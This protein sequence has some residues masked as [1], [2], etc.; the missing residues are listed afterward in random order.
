MINKKSA[1]CKDCTK[2]SI[3]CHGGCDDYAEYQEYV[4][5]IKS[6]RAVM[7]FAHDPLYGYFHERK[8]KRMHAESRSA[9]L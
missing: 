5:F 1:P 6:R 9:K 3:G 8:S 4:K 2:R 7:D